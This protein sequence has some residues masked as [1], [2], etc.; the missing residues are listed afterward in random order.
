[1][2]MIFTAKDVCSKAITVK[3][4]KMMSGVRD[5][6]LKHNIR[7]ILIEHDQK[8]VAIVTEKSISQY[9][10][11]DNNHTSLDEIVISKA[12]R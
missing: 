9:L 7:K 12:M 11:K 1:M 10:Y 4:T 3:S 6:M 8:P 2:H 5:T